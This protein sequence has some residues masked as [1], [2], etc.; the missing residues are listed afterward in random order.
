MIMPRRSKP[1]PPRLAAAL[2]WLL[3][4]LKNTGLSA[5][6]DGDSV[7][8]RHGLFTRIDVLAPTNGV[9]ENGPTRA[10]LRL[11]MEIPE[12]LSAFLAETTEV[13]AVANEAATLGALTM[14]AT[15]SS[16]AL[17]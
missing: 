13:L 2:D 5:K 7:I 12:K 15:K 16:L 3:T 11:K 10:I 14:T 8:V 1:S 4:A 9:F 6:H 17:A